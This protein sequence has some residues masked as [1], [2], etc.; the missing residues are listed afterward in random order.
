MSEEKKTKKIS[1]AERSTPNL[2]KSDPPTTGHS[3]DGIEEFDNPDPSWL[4]YLFYLTLFFCIGYWILY[5]SFPAQHNDGALELSQYDELN[6]SFDE[7]N[8]K[9]SAYLAD[10]R[11]ASFKDILKDDRLLQFALVG[12]KS[13]FHNNCSVCHGVGGRGNKGYPNLTAGS[14]LWGGT[15]EDIYQTIQFGIRSG[16]EET[17]DSQMAAFGR[18]GILTKEEIELLVD[19]VM[20][21]REGADS[22]SP[23][24][25]LFMEN[26]ASCHGDK[27]Q[28]GRDFGAPALNDAIW[29]YGGDRET[30]FDV[31]H[32]GR[33]GV[34]PYWHGKLDDDTIKQLAIYVHQLGGGEQSKV[35]YDK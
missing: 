34:M 32:N 3:W 24:H 19:Y 9:R 6:K 21:L 25:K 12:G 33:Q 4:R 26:C 22:A 29:L 2:K 15:P 1:K 14:W 17:R 23:A 18:D 16:H 20:H 5:P 35:S 11:K 7:L 28:G 8:K 30:I 10:F 27:G 31:I 13:A